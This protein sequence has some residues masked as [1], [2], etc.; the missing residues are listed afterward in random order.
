LFLLGAGISRDLLPLSGRIDEIVLAG[1][2]DDTNTIGRDTVGQYDLM[3]PNDPRRG[4][5]DWSPRIRA[6]LAWLYQWLPNDQR[7]YEALYYACQ[8]VYDHLTDE[9][10]NPI[11][12]PFVGQC[13]QELPRWWGYDS[14]A[15]FGP[16]LPP[17]SKVKFLTAEATSYISGIVAATLRPV[18][19]TPE[20][21]RQLHAPLLEACSDSSRVR[22]VDVVT[23][24][25]DILLESSLRAVGEDLE[26][27]FVSS[28]LLPNVM[29]WGGYRL[30][31]RGHVRLVKLHGSVDW[32]DIYLDENPRRR[33]MVRSSACPGSLADRRQRTW[34]S[35]RRSSILVGTSNKMLDYLKPGNITRLALFR[36]ALMQT[37]AIV[38]SGYSF[39]DKG[40]NSLLIAWARRGRRIA[41][42]NRSLMG[43]APPD[44]A[45]PSIARAWRVWVAAGILKPFPQPFAT[46]SWQSLATHLPQS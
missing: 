8:Q 18:S 15:G 6:F 33:M 24:N 23:L 38:V 5:D 46:A 29:R 41:V 2:S 45:N 35:V 34:S 22:F 26:D 43:D 44:T 30:E 12:T 17:R 9:F 31:G 37:R 3:Y 4:L 19:P 10:V 40:V 20:A 16:D 14:T 42:V 27:G 36:R 7:H 1:K 11:L 13:V 32:W 39:R 25:H 21:L 28:H